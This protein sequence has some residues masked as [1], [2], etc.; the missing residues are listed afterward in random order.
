VLEKSNAVEDI[1]LI[2]AGGSINGWNG[3]PKEKK[4]P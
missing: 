1:V 3:L 4:V 2:D